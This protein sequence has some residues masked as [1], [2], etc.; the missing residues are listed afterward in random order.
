MSI[1]GRLFAAMYDRVTGV[2]ERAGLSARRAQLLKE[3]RGR[4]LEIGA[5]TGANLPYYPD[6]GAAIT[7]AEPEPPMSR[8][9]TGKAGQLAR[10]VHI[11]NATAEAMPFDDAQFDTVVST[12]VLC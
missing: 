7:L 11:V 9:L 4:V 6:G 10:P 3:A 12:L 8:R 2:V 5:G 1:R